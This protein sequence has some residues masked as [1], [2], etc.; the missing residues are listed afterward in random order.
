MENNIF[1]GTLDS[2]VYLSR[3]NGMS[4]INK[5]QGFDGPTSVENLLIVN[6]Y[7]Y[8][9][10]EHSTYRRLLSESTGI[11]FISSEI[12][13]NYSLFQNYPNPFNP[14]T[15]IKY[16]I[17]KNSFVILKV[18]DLLGREISTLVN[19]LQKAG[20]YEIQFSNSGLTSGIYFYRMQA[21]NYSETKKMVYIK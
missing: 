2:G 9:S 21:G 19:E 17:S 20:V 1:A 3:N 7:I 10:T 11:N 8:S 16:Q 12:P 5:N 13:S 6:D 18:Y 4:W 14:S 15:N